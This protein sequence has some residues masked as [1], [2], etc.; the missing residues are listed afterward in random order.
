M[1]T[2]SKG[3]T[4]IG[5]VIGINGI[6]GQCI[7]VNGTGSKRRYTVAFSNGEVKQ[8]AKRSIDSCKDISQPQS[9]QISGSNHTPVIESLRLADNHNIDSPNS[10]S[11]CSD[12]SDNMDE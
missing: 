3:D 1:S 9:S 11:S 7:D 6:I 2:I 8:V 12:D 4:V 10:S 5:K